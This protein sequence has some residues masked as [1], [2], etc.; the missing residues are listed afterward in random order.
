MPR[1]DWAYQALWIPC[2]T[3]LGRRLLAAPRVPQPRRQLTTYTMRSLN[4]YDGRSGG[5]W[6]VASPA[7]AGMTCIDSRQ[8]GSAEEG[9]AAR[10]GGGRRRPRRRC[11][12]W[13]HS[14]PPPGLTA[15]TSNRFAALHRLPRLLLLRTAAAG[16]LL[17]ALHSCALPATGVQ[18]AASCIRWPGLRGGTSAWTSSVFAGLQREACY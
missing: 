10:S 4:R 15:C 6:S 9:Q 16:R 13:H 17:L 11:Y 7:S 8:V 18:D 3:A 5:V 14:R 2:R 1:C 12:F